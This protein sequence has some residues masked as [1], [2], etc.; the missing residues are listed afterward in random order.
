MAAQPRRAQVDC[1]ID[2]F[3]RVQELFD[4]V[5]RVD[6]G[7]NVALWLLQ[8]FSDLNDVKEL[9]ILESRQGTCL[10][11]F[12]FKEENNAS[13]TGGSLDEPLF[14][15]LAVSDLKPSANPMKPLISDTADSVLPPSESD[16]QCGTRVTLT[17]SNQA[18]VGPVPSSLD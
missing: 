17:H 7:D 11:P 15:D 12:D 18:P 14:Q 8:Q 5:E 9:S 16:G 2:A 4:G 3:S 6:G 1:Q 10:P 13:S